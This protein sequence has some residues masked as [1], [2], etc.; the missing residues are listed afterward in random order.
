MAVTI[1][2][3][4]STA[5]WSSGDNWSSSYCDVGRLSTSASARGHAKGHAN[6]HFGVEWG[7]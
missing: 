3:S 1:L 6:G 4:S 2:F 5:P 7:C